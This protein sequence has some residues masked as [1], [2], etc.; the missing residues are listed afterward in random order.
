M[1]REIPMHLPTVVPGQELP[2]DHREMLGLYYGEHGRPAPDT[3]LTAA[4]VNRAVDWWN[5]R[6][7]D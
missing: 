5:A 3:I 4:M 2:D 1:D 6:A 7:E